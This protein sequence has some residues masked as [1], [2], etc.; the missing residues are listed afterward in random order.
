[1]P[2]TPVHV[3][4][5]GVLSVVNDVTIKTANKHIYRTLAE[6]RV[7]PAWGLPYHWTLSLKKS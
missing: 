5:A 7:I 4:N 1:M 3:D 2:P 6:A